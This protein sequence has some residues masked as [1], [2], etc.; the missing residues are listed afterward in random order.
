MEDQ[1]SDL[2]AYLL[3]QNIRAEL[4]DLGVAMPTAGDAS[5][6]LGVSLKSILKSIVLSDRSGES[7]VIVLRADQRIDLKAVARLTGRR[8]LHFA[9]P[10]VVIRTTGFPPG[11]TPPIGHKSSMP[12]IMDEGI[13]RLKEGYGGGGRPELLL[14]ITPQELVKAS[15]AT[16]ACITSV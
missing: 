14:R 1:K 4:L 3:S 10:E 11:G 7:L 2:A 8:G 5:A 15:G 12:I 16:V 9:S 13:L 6:R